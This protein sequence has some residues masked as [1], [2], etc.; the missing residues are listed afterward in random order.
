MAGHAQLK[1]VMTECSK[2]QI[3]L[4]GLNYI[5]VR[6]IFASWC[7]KTNCIS[8]VSSVLKV[9]LEIVYMLQSYQFLLYF[10]SKHNFL[11]LYLKVLGF[12]IKLLVAYKLSK[13]SSWVYISVSVSVD[14]SRPQ[15]FRNMDN[16]FTV[17]SWRLWWSSRNPG[18]QSTGREAWKFGRLYKKQTGSTGVTA[19]IHVVVINLTVKWLLL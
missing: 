3:R 4:T 17:T 6:I 10:D 9:K 15:R 12:G 2:T 18:T 7:F 11:M 14:V 16:A 1:F 8:K 19:I 13:I 5:L